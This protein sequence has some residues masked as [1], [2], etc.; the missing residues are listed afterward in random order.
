MIYPVWLH[1]WSTIVSASSAR[2]SFIRPLL[3]PVLTSIRSQLTKV[4]GKSVFVPMTFPSEI[5]GQESREVELMV[6]S[7]F[8]DPGSFFGL[9]TMC[10]AHRAVLSVNR[11]DASTARTKMIAN[12]PDFCIMKAKSI[13]EMNSKM[14]DP[15]RALSD[16]AFDTIV[17]LL[18][19]SVCSSLRVLTWNC[20]LTSTVDC[21]SVRRSPNPPDRSQTNGRAAWRYYRREH[22]FCVDIVCH[23]Y[24]CFPKTVCLMRLH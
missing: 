5:S 14:Q 24:V 8:S 21:W 6:R 22:P 4:Q 1:I 16:E 2:D 15:Q 20:L 18:T 13:R 3:V 7:S 19:G 23:H 10:A 17:N 9:M 12:D 11:G